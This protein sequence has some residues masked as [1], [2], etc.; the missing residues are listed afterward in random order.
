MLDQ[1]D[2]HLDNVMTPPSV[3]VFFFSTLVL[4]VK[5]TKCLC[6]LCLFACFLNAACYKSHDL[7]V[8]VLHCAV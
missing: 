3:R 8:P 6:S 7:R 5:F 2:S 4:P 1:K